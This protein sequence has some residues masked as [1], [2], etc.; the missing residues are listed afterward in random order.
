MGVTLRD[1]MTSDDV[2]TIP[3]ETSLR[4]AARVM[5]G[6]NVGAAVVV[7]G[8]RIAGIFTERDHLRRVTMSGHD[9]AKLRI[10]E[11]MTPQVHVVDGGTSIEECM[12]LM[13][14]ERIRHLPV[15]DEGRVTGMISIG[16]LVKWVSSRQETEIRHLTEYITGNSQG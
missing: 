4:E 2:L 15:L 14:R 6:R 9:P 11:V 16:D 7:D 10:D 1:F 8:G 12:A 5:R 3:A 13:T